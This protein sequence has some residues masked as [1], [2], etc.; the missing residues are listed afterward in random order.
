MDGALCPP[1]EPTSPTWRMADQL[2]GGNLATTI[3]S[4]ADAGRSTRAISLELAAAFGVQVS[5][6]TV[7]SWLRTLRTASAAAS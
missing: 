4:L 1:M 2:A 7:A 6:V 3:L 5:N